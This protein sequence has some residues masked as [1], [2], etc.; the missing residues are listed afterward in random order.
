[1]EVKPTGSKQV[2]AGSNESLGRHPSVTAKQSVFIETL[3]E[4]DLDRR[5]QACDEILRQIDTLSAELKKAPTPSGVK[6][7]RRLVASFIREA[8]DQTYELNEETHWDRS[9]NRKS[10]ITVRN[11]NKALEELTSE[12]MEREKK[13]INL[14]AK[15]DEI[16]GM[17]L[18]LYI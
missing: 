8:M 16:R 3:K 17:L 4:N 15:L 11:I 6:K 13:Q 12:V 14:V 10:Y 7:Y 2:G 5:R 9:G 1:M 18:D